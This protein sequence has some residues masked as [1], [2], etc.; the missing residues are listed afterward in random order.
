MNL[1]NQGLLPQRPLTILIA[2]LGGEGGGMLAE[3]VVGA[4]M[5]CDYPVQSTS[6][7]GTAQRT[8]A[9][10]YYV[11]IYAVPAAQLEGR[12]PVMALMPTPGAVDV[13]AASEL[14][15]AAR[16]LQGAYIDAGTTVIASTHRV[17]TVAE[18]VNPG[19]GRADSQKMLAAVGAAAQ[20]A[21]L[22]DMALL[23]QQN[24]S[25]INAV[26]FGALA[27][28]GALPLPRAAC[29]LAI[30]ATGKGG[31][32]NLRG[33]AA[34][35]AQAK[36]GGA[37][38]PS[39][40]PTWQAATPVERVRQKFPAPT[41]DVLDAG[42]ARL[43]DYQDAAYATL[44]LNRLE[45][46]LALDRE[47]GGAASGFRLTCETGRQLALWMSYE[48]VFRVAEL[49]TRSRRMERVRH[50]VHAVAHDIVMVTEYLKPGLEDVCAI[51]PQS[52]AQR[53]RRWAVKNGKSF[54]V[55]LRIKTSTLYG[56]LLLRGLGALGAW[57]RHT[58]RYHTEQALILRWLGAIKRL[59]FAVQDIG[60]ALEIV[61]CARL[62]RG[63]GETHRNGVL[64][65]EKIFDT[66]VEGG[67]E[68]DPKK[69]SEAIRRARSAALANP[70]EAPPPKSMNS[71]PGK[72]IFWMAR[73]AS[74]TLPGQL[75]KTGTSVAKHEH[76]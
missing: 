33:F 36:D 73:A 53:L 39:S 12:I 65:F 20:R 66:I 54:S 71:D 44:Y 29:E 74:G 31:R 67:H 48:D 45:P 14:A 23:A 35:Y 15:E 5:R 38:A 50:D 61:D 27:G 70:E 72:P 21:E 26:L 1:E 46:I 28:S 62:V 22:F 57:R 8:G 37:A 51:L 52:L 9:T 58:S 40:A 47:A 32:A 19:D 42:V 6:I 24:G 56:F 11:E 59:G 63:Y 34:G 60:L 43:T 7:P 3:W 75:D 41:F 13:V 49:K 4:A 25:L 16:A 30:R 64:Q 68:S 55:P 76:T 18:K 10:T 69:L 17:Y 2:A